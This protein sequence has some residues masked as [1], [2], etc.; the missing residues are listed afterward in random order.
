MAS[1]L[2]VVAAACTPSSSHD[3]GRIINAHEHIQSLDEVP[4][5]LAAMD[6]LGIARTVLVGSSRFTITLR[7]RDGFTRIDDNNEELIRIIEAHPGRFEAW[8]TLDP[9]DPEALGKLERLVERGATGLK[10]YLGHGL[11][12]KT[13]R[14]WMF[15]QMAMDAPEMMP[16]YSFC[17]QTSLPI[18][19][20][21]NPGPKT[22]GFAQEFVAVLERFPD[23]KINCPHYMLSSILDSR[24]RELLDTY[25]NLYSDIS[26]GHDD[27]LDAGL[28]R[29]SENPEKFR[30][31]FL[32]YPDRFFFATDCV[33]TGARHKDTEWI[34]ARF[35]VYRDVLE[36]DW[37]TTPVIPETRLRGLSLPPE[38]VDR[39]MFRNFEEF[40]A[41]RPAGTTITRAVDWKRMG[42][43]K[44]ERTP[45]KRRPPN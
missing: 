22:P 36:K 19:Y 14:K 2:I 21:V 29:M 5:L 35:R 41:K 32:D 42:V 38:I 6:E 45:G 9:A 1:I 16:V 23:L 30:R 43:K 15:S 4:K 40:V 18:C 17:E 3:H 27:F 10:L 24:L 37:Y 39:V 7:H 33:I 20:H 44:L 25:P 8:P 31:L 34:S 26:Y 28:R 11:V 13:T 12:S